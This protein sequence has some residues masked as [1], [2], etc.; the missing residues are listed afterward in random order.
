MNRSGLD[1]QRNAFESLQGLAIL[2]F[3][4]LGDM[5]NG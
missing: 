2:A 3:K 1:F 5:L 4:C